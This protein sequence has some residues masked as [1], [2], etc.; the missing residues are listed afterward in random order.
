MNAKRGEG[1][2]G[3]LIA[4]WNLE[5]TTR[6]RQAHLDWIKA[7]LKQAGMD[8]LM[9]VRM[10]TPSVLWCLGWPKTRIDLRLR[11]KYRNRVYRHRGTGSRIV[12]LS[13]IHL[14]FAHQAGVYDLDKHNEYVHAQQWAC[15]GPKDAA[16]I[17]A[18][19]GWEGA[20]CEYALRT[21]ARHIC[22]R[23]RTA[24]GYDGSPGDSFAYGPDWSDVHGK[25]GD[26][27]YRIVDGLQLRYI[28]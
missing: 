8:R 24:S 3:D 19:R 12:G 26:T 18:W 1:R 11:K 16:R 22:Y 21:D 15:K 20:A 9:T 6:E 5:H 4:H 10:L 7:F 28:K 14:T 17:S 23:C 27:L 25:L 2:I 13:V